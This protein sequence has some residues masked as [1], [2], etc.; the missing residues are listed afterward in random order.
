MTPRV[1]AGS[2]TSSISNSIAALSAFALLPFGVV[3]DRFEL[4]AHAEA[5]RALEAHR[6]QVCPR[7]RHRQH[8]FVQ[9]A[10]GHRLR[11]QPVAAPQ[12]HRDHRNP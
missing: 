9:A 12:D 2:I 11:T 7:P 5:H 8:R 4:L 6:A 3:G 10:A 1:S